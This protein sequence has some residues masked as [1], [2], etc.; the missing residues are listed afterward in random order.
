MNAINYLRS[1]VIL[2]IKKENF[3]NIPTFWAQ[4]SKPWTLTCTYVCV[5]LNVREVR[6]RGSSLMRGNATIRLAVALWS[7]EV[8]QSIHISHSTFHIPHYTY[9]TWQADLRRPAGK[10]NTTWQLLKQFHR[11]AT[12]AL[13]TFAQLTFWVQ[14]IWHFAAIFTYS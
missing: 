4:V 1:P 14:I 2:K 6:V 7:C 11:N 3:S 13:H 8:V 9:A 5:S 12:S 10:L